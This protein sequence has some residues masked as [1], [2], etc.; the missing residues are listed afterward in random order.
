LTIFCATVVQVQR[1]FIKTKTQFIIIF[2]KICFECFNIHISHLA[3]HSII[4]MTLKW[5][6]KNI[7]NKIIVFIKFWQLPNVFFSLFNCDYTHTIK[8]IALQVTYM[9]APN[10]CRMLKTK[11]QLV[12]NKHQFKNIQNIFLLKSNEPTKY[13]ENFKQH[14]DFMSNSTTLQCFTPFQIWKLLGQSMACSFF[15][16]IKTLS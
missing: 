2:L 8:L 10:M 16:C 5:H 11:T 7:S 1:S 13:G 9:C 12:F 15:F 4:D 14:N 6:H 3:L